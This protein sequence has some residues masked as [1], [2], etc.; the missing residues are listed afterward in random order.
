[1]FEN[2]D[3]CFVKHKKDLLWH[4]QSLNYQSIVPQGT[5][6]VRCHKMKA[7][8]LLLISVTSIVNCNP[9]EFLQLSR[10][11][12]KPDFDFSTWAFAFP[13]MCASVSRRDDSSFIISRQSKGELLTK[14]LQTT[15]INMIITVQL[16][17][18]L[19]SYKTL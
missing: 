16:F 15:E 14:N 5:A 11:L 7:I 10:W 2:I 3:L 12:S 13:V 6:L 18:V 19:L 17:L 9:S 8:I 1:M 4:L